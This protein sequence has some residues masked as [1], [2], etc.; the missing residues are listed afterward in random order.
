MDKI[1]Q[2]RSALAISM[3]YKIIEISKRKFGAQMFWAGIELVFPCQ[4]RVS[5]A[6]AVGAIHALIVHNAAAI[7]EEKDIFEMIVGDKTVILPVVYRVEAEI[8][9]KWNYQTKVWCSVE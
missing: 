7:L 4:K 2:A 1:K 8:T 5:Q 3:N 9:N 6:V